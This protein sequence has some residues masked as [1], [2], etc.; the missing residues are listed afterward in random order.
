MKKRIFCFLLVLAMVLSIAPMVMAVEDPMEE[1]FTYTDSRG[2]EVKVPK[3]AFAVKVVEF[4]PGEKWTKDESVKDPQTILGV[5]EE[6]NLCL[7]KYGTIV[8]EFDVDIVDNEGMDIY[9][10]ETGPQVE[11]TKVEVSVDGKEWIYVGDAD[12]SLSGVDLNGKVPEGGR[13]HYV[14]VTDLGKYG[15]SDYPGADIKAVAGLNV[16]AKPFDDLP[17]NAYYYGPVT[18]AYDNEIT[19]GVGD[20][21][22]DPN[23]SCKRQDVV[24]YLWRLNGKPEATIT[25]EN[26]PFTD[27]KLSSY[28][29]DALLWAYE[30]EVVK[31][32]TDTTFCPADPILRSE[33]VA[34]LY[35]NLGNPEY[36][37]ENPFV[38]LREGAYYVDAVLWAYEN[39]ITTG[40]DAT[41]FAPKN[42]CTR[43]QVVTFLYRFDQLEKPE[44][45]PEA[46]D[47][48]DVDAPEELADLLEYMYMNLEELISQLEGFG[49][50]EDGSYSNGAVTFGPAAWS[51][52]TD[53][54]GTITIHGEYPVSL[55]G[56]KVGMTMQQA[57]QTLMDD[58]W[59]SVDS[60]D[61]EW[62]NADGIV[63]SLKGED[64]VTSLTAI[65]Y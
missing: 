42:D 65:C 47:A 59:A 9:V 19:T 33:F 5:P 32:K 27:V 14:R 58:G 61:T 39:G 16:K 48:P 46:P 29:G 21:K 38:D 36:T 20:D 23:A 50:L 26:I 43:A 18:W 25:A 35:R 30:N 52:D 15:N 57:Q 22:F 6:S 40:I 3:N 55:G 1:M 64:T 49:K 7:G 60:M 17:P 45:E 8:L 31:G 37:A 44:E 4:T 13:Y 63:L 56:V 54:V 53:H 2:N 34:L 41:H 11:P 12:G 62:K 28:Y 24:T 51:E 10:F